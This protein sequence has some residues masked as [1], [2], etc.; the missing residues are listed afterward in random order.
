MRPS[1]A[2]MRPRADL[3][4]DGLDLADD[5]DHR[6]VSFGRVGGGGA[7]AALALAAGELRRERVE[8]LLPERAE[9]VEPVLDLAER[10]R[11]DGVEPPG[12][13]GPDRRE[14][15]VAQD[16]EVLRD[17]RLRDP[18]LRL[19]D[20]GDRPGGQLAV[21]EQLEDPPPDR[22]AED[23]ERVHEAIVKATLI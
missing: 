19:D 1:P 8:A 7:Q 17:G 20:R 2:A 3:A 5:V 12:A 9:V 15:A 22:V 10:R 16:L 11:V 23:V 13:L 14:P 6:V 21:G 18:E 4:L